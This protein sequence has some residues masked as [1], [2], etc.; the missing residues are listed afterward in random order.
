MATINAFIEKFISK[1]EQLQ[2]EPSHSIIQTLK[3]IH[4]KNPNATV[5]EQTLNLTGHS[6][7]SKICACLGNALKDDMVFSR[8]IMADAFLGD[9]GI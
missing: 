5:T 3:D 6:L 1:S 8:I 2:I 7:S 9:D 4:D